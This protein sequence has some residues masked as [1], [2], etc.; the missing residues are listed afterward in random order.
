MT[1][2]FGRWVVFVCLVL[3]LGGCSL[4]GGVIAPT[5]SP[6]V[7]PSPTLPPTPNADEQASRWVLGLTEEPLDLYP[8]SIANSTASP[9]IQL[10]YPAPLLVV[11]EAYTTTGVLTSVPSFENGDVAYVTTTV[12]LDSNGAITQTQTEVVSSVPQLT[13]TYHW[14]P[15]LSWEDGTPLTAADSVF[16]YE[17]LRSSAD[18]PQLAAK[19]EL[20][21]DYVALDQHT[22]RAYLAPTRVDPNYLLTVW[23]PLPKHLFD[24]TATPASVR[25]RLARTPLGY[26]PYQLTNWKAGFQ[27]DF[28]RR[29]NANAAL[30]DMV[31]AQL[32]SDLET[33]DQALV[34]GNVDVGW[35]EE[36]PTTL[37]PKLQQQ[38]QDDQLTVRLVSTPVW[39]HIDFNLAVVALQD[40]RMRH[41]LAYGF[42]RAKLA[43][44]LYGAED[45]VWHS[46][47][48]P[49]SWA[50]ADDQLARYTYDPEQA[51]A[52]L[53]EMNY[54]DIDGD[55]LRESPEGQPFA[56]NLLTSEQTPVRQFIAEQFKQDMQAI[57]LQINL[58]TRSTQELYSPQGPLFQRQFQ[59]A[60][61]G[62]LRTVDPDGAVLW[63]CAA[64][65]NEINGWTGDNFTGW[66]IDTADEAIRSAT[67]GIDQDARAQSYA[68]QQ[69]VFTRELP[70]LPIFAR[71]QV[72]LS[73]P[74]IVNVQPD[75]F[76]PVTWNVEQ[77]QRQ[78]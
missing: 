18:T 22:T 52:L 64:I 19:Q 66:C 46:W 34:S 9:L 72:V 28:A 41:A 48:A 21:F 77:W 62:W 30:P 70:V 78:P 45:I 43:T 49:Q 5:S 47:I 4:E 20:T 60:L 73:A 54:T 6:A 13:I 16:A 57:G 25:E 23:Q 29:P 67:S 56:L 11:D 33:L 38:A 76:A 50:Y 14:N 53:D 8:Y 17:L 15:N 63:S 35:S 24:A 1:G 32:Y 36:L 7:A 61:F 51:R 37:L 65:P 68:Q 59:L 26:G 3:A 74:G 69:Q 12:Y 2:R 39:E 71:Q 44:D 31:I 75:V 42:N 10:L 40:I 55:G 27:L 58:E